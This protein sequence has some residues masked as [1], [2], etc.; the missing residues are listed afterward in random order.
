MANLA[1]LSNA[2]NAV[3]ALGSLILVTPDTNL[4]YQPMPP[5]GE[6]GQPIGGSPE[7]LLFDF[8][9]EQKVILKSQIT[10][11][12][13]ENNTT[14]QNQIALAPMMIQTSGFI[15]ELNDVVPK[16]L[17]FLKVAAERLTPI[18]AFL[19]SLSESAIRAYNIAKQAYDILQVASSN[20]TV[21]SWKSFVTGDPNLQT[22]Q[23]R[24]FMQFQG[25][26]AMRTLFKVQTPWGV[27]ENMAIETLT[28]IQ[29]E[30]SRSI[31]TFEV[32][33]KEMNFASTEVITKPQN[34]SGRGKAQYSNKTNVG[35]YR[36]KQETIRVGT[37][38]EG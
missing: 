11:H 29:D 25:Y 30:E 12:F 19:P 37:L 20:Q 7:P 18:G 32:T 10:D 15:C 26:R 33:F 17:Q 38:V 36:P 3:A 14:R 34:I 6:D 35:A 1:D 27:F 28:A 24:M 4:G 2:T 13:I 21:D 9:G 8:E 31:T 23:S 22:K 5:L 16:E